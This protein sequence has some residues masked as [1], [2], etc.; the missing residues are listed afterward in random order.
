[1]KSITDENKG[2]QL[3][4]ALGQLIFYKNVVKKDAELVVVLES[5]FSDVDILDNDPINV[6]WKEGD[7]FNASE[8]TKEKLKV[9]FDQ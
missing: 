3:K 1:M 8:K 9:I 2:D 4:K 5:Y 7:S 6:V